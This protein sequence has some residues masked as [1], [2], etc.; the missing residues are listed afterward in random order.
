MRKPHFLRLRA[1]SKLRGL[2][3]HH[4]AVFLCVRE[5]LRVAVHAFADEKISVRRHFG[6]LVGRARIGAIGHRQAATRFAHYH[7]RGIANAIHLYDPSVLEQVPGGKR[8]V[9]CLCLFHLEFGEPRNAYTIAIAGDFMVN[10]KGIDLECA[11]FKHFSFWREF[12]ILYVEGQFGGDHAKRIAYPRES[13]R[14]DEEKRLR[15]LGIRNGEEHAGEAGDVVSVKMGKQDCVDGLRGPAFFF[16]GDL[17]AFAA[18]YENIGAFGTAHE[19][20]EPALRERH[21]AAGAEETYI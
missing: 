6:D 7:I 5:L 10:L 17:G 16:H 20:C 13:L 3:H 14:P 4:V 9:V 15:P 19:A 1:L 11:D 18:V 2:L 12:M 21:H 8:H